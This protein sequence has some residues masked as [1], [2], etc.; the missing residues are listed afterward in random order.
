MSIISEFQELINKYG[1]DLVAETAALLLKQ[2][3]KR[4]EQSAKRPHLPSDKKV[5]KPDE[6][7]EQ[8]KRQKY[9]MLDGHYKWDLAKAFFSMSNDDFFNVYG[10]NF[11][12]K[13]R[14]W[15]E[16]KETLG[17][18]YLKP[19]S[20]DFGAMGGDLTQTITVKIGNDLENI[21]PNITIGAMKN[22][23]LGG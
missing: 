3:L 18:E 8:Q 11:V 22:F 9:G 1:H 23:K 14:L 16:A 12:P 20:V 15:T 4:N 17:A 10:F 2:D 5:V 19:P 13:G 21:V 7:K 6:K